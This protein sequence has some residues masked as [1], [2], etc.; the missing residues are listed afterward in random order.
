MIRWVFIP[1]VLA[2]LIAHGP[3]L[4]NK[5]TS[6]SYPVHHNGIV[7]VS[8]A[9]SGIGKHAAFGLAAEGFIVYAGVRSE[10]DVEKLNS[11]NVDKSRGGGVVPVIFDVTKE[12]TLITL[13]NKV[14]NSGLPLVAIVNNAGVSG[15]FPVEHAN[16]SHARH[17]F[18]VNYFG[19]LSLTQ[20][21][22]PLIRKSKGR[23]LFVSSV[24]SFAWAYGSSIYSGTKRA[25]EALVDSLRIELR[26]FEV[27]VSSIQPGFIRTNIESASR[28]SN[29]RDFG[30]TD[31]QYEEYKYFWDNCNKGRAKSFENAGS[32]ELTTNA[33]I[34]AITSSK[35]QTRYVVGP[36]TSL[37]TGYQISML[38]R[39]IPERI[40]D[41]LAF[42]EYRKTGLIDQKDTK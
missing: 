24:A 5:L 14:L 40:V 17:M 37:L 29:Y 27:S 6:P 4:L 15:R 12:E 21:F 20:H 28:I 36:A 8:G 39:F 1:L 25:V 2:I 22:L 11:E 38:L 16:I 32:V 26:E 41:I 34:D 9:S 33:I 42:K 7:V 31:D 23:I 35:P 3:K 18:D 19:T 30:V 10:K 13:K